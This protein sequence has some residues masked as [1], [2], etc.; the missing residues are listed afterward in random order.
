MGDVMTPN[1]VWATSPKGT[2][3][4]GKGVCV[5]V[6]MC[7]FVYV[8]ACMLYKPTCM[9][10]CAYITCI[11]LCYTNSH[12]GITEVTQISNNN[13]PWITS[14]ESRIASQMAPYS[15]FSALLLTRVIMVLGGS[16][17]LYR[18]YSAM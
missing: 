7:A 4:I 9:S 8:Y 6:R 13:Y 10:I 18:E 15:F 1:Y 5:C 2:M 12:L 11:R 16:S 14:A 3:I 17:A